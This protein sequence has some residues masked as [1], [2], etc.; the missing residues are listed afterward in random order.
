MEACKYNKFTLSLTSNLF[1]LQYLYYI[2][3]HS[4]FILKP[5]GVDIFIFLFYIIFYISG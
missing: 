1:A 2:T 5:N 3:Q 4:I